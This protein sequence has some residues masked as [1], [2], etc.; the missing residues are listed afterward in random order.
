MNEEEEKEELVLILLLGKEV[1][2][3]ECN[4]RGFMARNRTL[5]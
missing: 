1:G 2:C 4:K 3:G 5:Y